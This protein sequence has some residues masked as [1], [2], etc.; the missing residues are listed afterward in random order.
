MKSLYSIFLLISLVFYSEAQSDS[1]IA[2]LKDSLA[3][4]NLSDSTTISSSDSLSVSYKDSIQ[5]SIPEI[6]SEKSIKTVLGV[7]SFYSRSFEGRK[8]ATGEIF[9]HAN[10]TA[11]SNNFKLNTW[12][13]VTNLKNG[14]SVIVRINDRMHPTMAKK[15]RVVDLTSTAA[16][17][18]GLL[19]KNGVIKVKTEQVSKGTLE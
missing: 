6:I 1:A 15:G 12:I 16:K 10:L 9:R 13:R 2:L 4:T 11:A 14:E 7:A 17:K 3:T 8:T 5:K 18:I 19:G